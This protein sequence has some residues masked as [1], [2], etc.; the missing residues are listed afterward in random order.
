MYIKPLSTVSTSHSAT[1]VP[2]RDA[3]ILVVGLVLYTSSIIFF[4]LSSSL[5]N[6]PYSLFLTH[7]VPQDAIR[8][9]AME[10][11][12]RVIEISWKMPS[13]RNGSVSYNLS[14]TGTQPLP[15]P[16]EEAQTPL[17]STAPTVP[18]LQ[19]TMHCPLQYTILK[20]LP[21]TLI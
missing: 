5:Y 15:Y 3:I 17:Y 9:T 7:T 10:V 16:V 2:I 13:D 12:D 6:V 19:S 18:L 8:V 11:R 14:Y 4:L 1:I 20:C 21:T